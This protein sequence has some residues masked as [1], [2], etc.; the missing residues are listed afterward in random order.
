MLRSL[1]HLRLRAEPGTR[2]LDDGAPVGYRDISPNSGA[3][4]GRGDDADV[5]V[6]DDTGWVSRRH[7]LFEVEGAQWLARDYR[8]AHGTKMLVAGREIRLV[9]GIPTPVVTGVLVVLAS[10]ARFTVDVIAPPPKGSRTRDPP[11]PSDMFIVDDDLL[12]LADALLEPR[13]WTPGGLSPPPYHELCERLHISSTALYA[14]AERLRALD[15][16]RRHLP[17]ASRTSLPQLAD[18]VAIAYPHLAR[19]RSTI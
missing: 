17:A 10:V 19:S 6:A 2:F 18:A 12:Q 11:H 9:S 3:I 16:V 7:L 4:V 5:C 14:R 8:S 15:A 1:G 13:R